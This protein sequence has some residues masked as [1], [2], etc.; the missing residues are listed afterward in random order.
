MSTTK[1]INIL[2]LELNSAEEG[3]LQSVY[4]SLFSN[5][6]LI[7]KSIED[8][9]D[10]LQFEP[11]DLVVISAPSSKKVL[12][13]KAVIISREYQLPIAVISDDEI[14]L[15]N[16]RVFSI[17]TCGEQ[18]TQLIEQLGLK[19]KKTNQK[20]DG[21][22]DSSLIEDSIFV[23]T[24]QQYKRILFK[25][26]LFIKSDHVYLEIHTLKER[27]LVRATFKDYVEKLPSKSFFRAHKSYIVNIQHIDLINQSD[28]V[29]NQVHI[30]ISREFK[31]FITKSIKT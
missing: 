13:E 8:F 25:D 9:S 21:S 24:N 19:Q 31:A 2:I 18:L 7:T 26:I 27:Y 23:K 28:V 12:L 15:D 17:N 29:I 11:V 22:E 1:G 3:K 5:H 10:S 4:E 14:D 16:L 30:P 20:T 6:S